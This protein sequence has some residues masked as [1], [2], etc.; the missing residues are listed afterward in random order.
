VAEVQTT[1]QIV[2]TPVRLPLAVL[3]S[4]GVSAMKKAVEVAEADLAICTV[5][6]ELAAQMLRRTRSIMAAAAV[7][8]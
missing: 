7:V 1:L 3:V 5:V 2:G 4:A 6:K 8:R